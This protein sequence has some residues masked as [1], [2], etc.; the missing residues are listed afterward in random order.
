MDI[1]FKRCSTKTELRQILNLQQ[2][3]HLQNINVDEKQKEGF[4]TVS[5]TLE[6]LTEMNAACPH[7]IAK[8]QDKVV[9]YAL[10]MHPRFGNDIEVL[11]PM[12]KEINSV[13]P[14]AEPFM[15]MG[16]ICIDKEYRR[17]G[18]FRK[19]YETMKN[20]LQP[21][22]TSIV[23]EV[24]ATNLRSLEAHYAVG[25][26]ELKTYHAGGQDWKLIVLG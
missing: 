26:E 10:C 4:V 22:F 16:Q 11:K 2:K 19:L 23:T 21:E 7:I 8:D 18:I 25:F 14:K 5:H 24:D 9:G 20:S 13:I 15:V 1:I 17:K 3:N 12:F 6:L